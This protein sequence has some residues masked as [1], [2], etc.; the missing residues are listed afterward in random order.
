MRE[1]LLDYLRQLNKE[2]FA[3]TQSAEV[4]PLTDAIQQNHNIAQELEHEHREAREDE[5]QKNSWRMKE[6]G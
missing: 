2:A 4:L 6:K 1:F 5:E 3:I